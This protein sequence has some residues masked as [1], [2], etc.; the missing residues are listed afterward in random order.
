[1][2]QLYLKPRLLWFSLH[3]W[4]KCWSWARCIDAADRPRSPKAG[5]FMEMSCSMFGPDQLVPAVFLCFSAADSEYLFMI[6]AGANKLTQCSSWIIVWRVICE[7][8][9]VCVLKAAWGCR[10]F[11]WSQRVK[12]T[13][14]S[15]VSLQHVAASR[16]LRNNPKW[17]RAD[18]TGVS[19]ASLTRPRQSF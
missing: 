17:N 15:F 7:F 18:D 19:S 12:L 1:M 6:D 5:M 16:Q 8:W 9:S 13:E 2:I 10:R 14:H 11:G 4:S 3:I